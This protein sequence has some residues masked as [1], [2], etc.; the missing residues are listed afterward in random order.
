M[1]GLLPRLAGSAAEVRYVAEGYG[2]LN[3]A[4]L[5]AGGADILDRSMC[6]DGLLI[7]GIYEGVRLP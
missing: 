1:A 4:R 5:G 2:L 7:V 6:D 3:R